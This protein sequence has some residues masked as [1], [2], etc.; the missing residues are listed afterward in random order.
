MDSEALATFVAVHRAGGVSNAVEHLNRSQPAIS[1]RIALLEEKLGAPL[2][3]RVSAG[4]ALSQAGEALLPYAERVLAALQDAAAA[5]E[6]LRAGVAGSVSVAVVGTLANAKLTAT[7]KGFAE[8]H[9]KVAVTLRT[10]TSAE[11]SEY[12]RRGEAVIGLRYFE[13]A[14]PDIICRTLTPEKLVV[15]CSSGHRLAGGKVRS[16]RSLKSEHWLAFPERRSKQEASAA[17]IAA[18][19]LIHNVADINCMPVDSLTA[20]KRL[21][22]AGFGIALLPESSITEELARKSIATIEVVD[23]QVANPVSVIVRSGGYLSAASRALLETL[24]SKF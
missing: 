1:R 21:I 13:D 15:T 20:Q 16:L 12:V 10:A 8:A 19:F 7:L 5:M 9:P 2:F 23:L 17:N 22:E 4:F 14:S 3:E 11:V 6:E 18:Q 24:A